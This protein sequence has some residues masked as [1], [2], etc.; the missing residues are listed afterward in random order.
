MLGV[1][2]KEERLVQSD[3]YAPMVLFDQAVYCVLPFQYI[4]LIEKAAVLSEGLGFEI[5]F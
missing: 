1:P 2:K 5:W 3:S 4:F